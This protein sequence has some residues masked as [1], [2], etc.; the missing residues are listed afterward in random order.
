MKLKKFYFI[1]NMIFFVLTALVVYTLMGIII[2][3]TSL[4]LE[5][6]SIEANKH[7][8]LMVDEDTRLDSIGMI[9]SKTLRYNYTLI[10][11]NKSQIDNTELESVLRQS[12]VTQLKSNNNLQWFK[13]NSINLSYDIQSYLYGIHYLNFNPPSD[14]IPISLT[15]SN[16]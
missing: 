2:P 3:R 5:N 12:I 7:T 4:T 14:I 11:Y 1:R 6:I 16:K 15:F 8:P 9:N 13:M 10:N